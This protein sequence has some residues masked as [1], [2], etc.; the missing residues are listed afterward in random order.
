MSTFHPDCHKW[1]LVAVILVELES[2]SNH[3]ELVLRDEAGNCTFFPCLL[4]LLN[5][6][7]IWLRCSPASFRCIIFNYCKFEI[8]LSADKELCTVSGMHVHEFHAA[9][10]VVVVEFVSACLLDSSL[11][12]RI[13]LSLLHHFILIFRYLDE[14]AIQVLQL[15]PALVSGL[16]VNC[17]VQLLTFITLVKAMDEI[18]I[19]N[20]ILEGR[21]DHQATHK[22]SLLFENGGEIA[23]Q[24]THEL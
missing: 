20:D 17:L 18:D 19:T 2:F 8:I 3:L 21:I 15:A 9:F 6:E 16:L 1:S 5:S 12:I 7:I 22:E 14:V 11:I 23:V 13:S 4:R 24:W 10:F